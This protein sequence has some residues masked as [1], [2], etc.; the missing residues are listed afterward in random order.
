MKIIKFL[1]ILILSVLALGLIAGLFIKK[2]FHYEK[3]I[4]INAPK[5]VV[6]GYISNFQNHEKWSQWKKIDPNM[7]TI[8][9]GE[10]GKT[11]S[12]MEWSSDN[13]KVGSGSQTITNIIEGERVDINLDF[14]DRGQPTAFYNLSGDSLKSKATWGMDMH[15]DYPFNVMGVFFSGMMDDMLVTGLDML[16]DAAEKRK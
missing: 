11:G 12:R 10:D 7:K 8:I 15:M 9:T 3:S 13:S 4:E 2:D 6:W 5:S 14:G 1:L 16:K